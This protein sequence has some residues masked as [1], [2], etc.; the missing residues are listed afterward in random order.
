LLEEGIT[1]YVVWH[2]PVLPFLS[3]YSRPHWDKLFELINLNTTLPCIFGIVFQERTALA[4]PTKAQNEYDIL[5]TSI[6]R[7]HK[8]KVV[9]CGND[10]GSCVWSDSTPV[11]IIFRVL[12]GT[13]T[14]RCVYLKIIWS[15]RVRPGMT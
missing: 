8:A 10:E 2:P 9:A 4:N 7:T 12:S 14:S 11:R 6:T 13:K 15:R 5:I 1:V 3:N